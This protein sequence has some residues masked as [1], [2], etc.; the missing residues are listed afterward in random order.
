MLR[1]ALVLLAFAHSGMGFAEADDK[2]Q[3]VHGICQRFCIF[4]WPPFGRSSCEHFCDRFSPTP[5]PTPPAPSPTPPAP[6]PTPPPPK[7]TPTPAPMPPA[8]APTPET[9][10]PTPTQVPRGCGVALSGDWPN[11]GAQFSSEYNYD[12][13]V[14]MKNAQEVAF[15]PLWRYDWRA[16]EHPQSGPWTYI[17]MDWCWQDGVDGQPDPTDGSPGLLGWNEPD[18][19]GQCPAND[20][21]D[22]RGIQEFVTLAAKYK[23]Q[24]KFVVSP[25]PGGWSDW[26]DTFLSQVKGHG[27]V[28]VD[29]LAYHHYVTCNADTTG[30]GMYGE[31]EEMLLHHIKLMYKWNAQGFNIKGIWITEIACA[32]SGGWGNA[33]F[34]WEA[35]KPRVLMNKF[36][37]IINNHKELQAWAWFG[38]GGFG[39]L[40]EHGSGALTDLGRTYFRNCHGDREPVMLKSSNNVSWSAIDLATDFKRPAGRPGGLSF[41]PINSGSVNVMV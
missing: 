12:L 6:T 39:Q 35:D 22:Q 37:D 25:A 26:L 31:M 29:Y 20:A 4:F 16:T 32:P 33:P 14:M 24:D 5:G 11:C 38:Y 2:L 30:D 8:P 40:W 9:P 41:P 28:D 1:F 10:A 19:P 3:G 15:W 23:K 7:P 34:H 13:N 21:A 27:F 36:I 17:S 18:V